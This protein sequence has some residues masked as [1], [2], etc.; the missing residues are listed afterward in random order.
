MHY[1]RDPMELFNCSTSVKELTRGLEYTLAYLEYGKNLNAQTDI[2]NYIYPAMREGIVRDFWWVVP[3]DICAFE[4][5]F[6][7]LKCI[8]ARSFSG[9]K[10]RV[11]KKSPGM[12]VVESWGRRFYACVLD[13][14][15]V[16]RRTILVDIDTDFLVVSD[17]GKSD[18]TCLIGKRRP[19][20]TPLELANRL[21]VKITQPAI[22]TIAYSTNGGFTPM[23]CRHFGDELAY[24]FGREKFVSHLRR[25]QR[26]AQYYRDF[27]RQG[28]KS[29]YWSAARLDPAYRGENNNYA[30]L[31]L[32]KNRV[33][34]AQKE[35]QRILRVDSANPAALKNAGVVYFA[36]KDYARAASCFRAVVRQRSVI[37]EIRRQAVLGLARVYFR[38]KR[39]KEAHALFMRHR[40]VQPLSGETRYYL[41]RIHEAHK[42]YWQAARNYRHC[43]R[44][45]FG[46][47]DIAKKLAAL[48]FK[49]AG[50]QKSDIINYVRIRLAGFTAQ[51]KGDS[52]LNDTVKAITRL[53]G[54]AETNDR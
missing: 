3:G 22:V 11:I 14:L 19:W 45:G 9:L 42:E 33:G 10:I 52:G 34:A 27:L 51:A 48:S 17:I 49:L 26:A 41:A 13:T 37:K 25:G 21:A 36:K 28:K 18:N 6:K 40:R 39:L 16:C 12:A 47:I 5:N 1:A 8:M 30:P 50:R 46:R 54:E 31:Y 43:V 53:L 29:G 4:T 38:Q 35:L 32:A 15:P 2:G 20:I 7:R 24:R 44:L 23:A